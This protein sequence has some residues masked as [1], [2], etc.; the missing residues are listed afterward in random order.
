MERPTAGLDRRAQT[1]SCQRDV[2]SSPFISLG[3]TFYILYY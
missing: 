1:N 2:K 3:V